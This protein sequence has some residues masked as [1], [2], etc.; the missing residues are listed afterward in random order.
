MYAAAIWL[1][2]TVYS[3]DTMIYALILFLLLLLAALVL[4]LAGVLLARRQFRGRFDG[5][6]D[7]FPYFSRLHPGWQRRPVAFPGTG[8]TTLRGDLYAQSGIDP[9]GLIVVFHGYG[10]SHGDYLP[11][12]EYFTRRGYLVLAF[13]GSGVGG[14]DGTLRG[15]PQHVLDLQSCLRY[16]QSDPDLSGLPLL[17]YGHSWGGY[18]ADCVGALEDFPICGIVSASAF[19]TSLSALAPHVRRHYGPLAPIPLLGVRLVQWLRFGALNGITAAKGLAR[20]H[21]PVLITQSDD[22][23]I[24]PYEKNYM[25]LYRCFRGDPRFTFLPLTGHDH[26][27]TTPH[28]VDVQKLRLLKVLRTPDPPHEAIDEINRLKTVT[29][30][31]LLGSFADFFDRCLNS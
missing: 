5:G 24:L 2:R 4:F 25:A 19:Y 12:C 13:D 30:E 8:N 18:A 31:A 10:M 28:E 3:G 20:Q 11:E 15:L 1:R 6:G 7:Y 9:K 17:L 23:R 29:D 26:N 16:I 27:I 22:D 21:C 14:S